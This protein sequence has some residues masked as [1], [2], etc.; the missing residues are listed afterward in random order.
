MLAY[1]KGVINQ[2]GSGGWRK[3]DVDNTHY[4][5]HPKYTYVVP[6]ITCRVV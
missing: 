5:R 6:N 2:K 4:K 3:V 1:T